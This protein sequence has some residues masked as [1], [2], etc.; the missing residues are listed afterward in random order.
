M[1][2]GLSRHQMIRTLPKMYRTLL[3]KLKSFDFTMHAQIGEDYFPNMLSLFSAHTRKPEEAEMA[4]WCGGKQPQ[5]IDL[6]WLCLD[7]DTVG[8]DFFFFFF[9]FWGGAPTVRPNKILESSTEAGDAKH[10]GASTHERFMRRVTF[11]D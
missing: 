5:N 7:N 8:E 3:E 10:T 9:F 11:Y 4:P 6:I 2:G 1:V